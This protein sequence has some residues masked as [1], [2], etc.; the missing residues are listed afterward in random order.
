ME[1]SPAGQVLRDKNRIWA[2]PR[3][4]WE[5]ARRTRVVIRMQEAQPSPIL[6]V[7]EI[8]TDWKKASRRKAVEGSLG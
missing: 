5:A 7:H 1:P 4:P 6:R 2:L 8:G 3:R